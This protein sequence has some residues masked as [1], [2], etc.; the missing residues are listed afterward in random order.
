MATM[1]PGRPRWWAIARWRFTGACAQLQRPASCPWRALMAAAYVIRCSFGMPLVDEPPIDVRHVSDGMQM[2][3]LP[4][5]PMA[6]GCRCADDGAWDAIAE[7]LLGRRIEWD[8]AAHAGQE[9]EES[10]GEAEE[11][12]A[13]GWVVSPLWRGF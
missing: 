8:W 9:E 5:P 1:E 2:Q 12:Q 7:R 10:E 3:P 11:E 13:A 4:A 6:I